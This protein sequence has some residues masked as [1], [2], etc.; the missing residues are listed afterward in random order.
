MAGKLGALKTKLLNKR[1][2]VIKE[3]WASEKTFKHFVSTIDHTHI[4]VFVVYD[5]M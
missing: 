4:L 5:I 2:D 1:N 3:K